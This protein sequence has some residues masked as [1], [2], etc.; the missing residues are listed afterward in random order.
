M[1]NNTDH[2]S[3]ADSAVV[4]SAVF[5]IQKI[6]A[7]FP[8]RADTM[9]IDTR[10]TDEPH[11][12]SRVFRVYRPV[13]AHYHATCD[14]YLSVL[15]GRA[16]FFLGE[17]PTFE[18]SLGQLIFFKQGTIHGIPEILEEPFVVLA[19]DTPRRDPSDVHFVNPADGTPESF[20]ESKRLY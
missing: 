17:A 11:A 7:S 5:D 13:A 2:A 14:E 6:A 12:S 20:I 4:A 15:S 1:T 19:V 16:K 3:P 9:L 10:L 8:D 18:V